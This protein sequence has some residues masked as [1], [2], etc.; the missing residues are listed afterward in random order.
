VLQYVNGLLACVLL[1]WQEFAW[2]GVGAVQ[3]MQTTGVTRRELGV[4]SCTTVDAV[5]EQG[6]GTLSH[7]AKLQANFVLW[8]R[9]VHV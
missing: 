8:L 1:I 7:L 4:R 2:L 3:P 5:V 6:H 9:S